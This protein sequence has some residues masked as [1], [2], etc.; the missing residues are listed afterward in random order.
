M[1]FG[2]RLRQAGDAG[3]PEEQV[4]MPAAD[5]MLDDVGNVVQMH[6][7]RRS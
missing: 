5:P 4:E 7:R 6:A 1:L 3:E 2:A